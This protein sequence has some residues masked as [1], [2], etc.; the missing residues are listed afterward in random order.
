MRRIP[1]LT[2]LATATMVVLL[3]GVW[4]PPAAAHGD[5]AAISVVSGEPGGDGSVHYRVRVVYENDGD[6]V[7]GVVGTAIASAAGVDQPAVPLTAV[8]GV[9]GD[10]EATVALPGP[11]PWTVRFEATDPEAVLSVEGVVPST[12]MPPTTTS[13][14]PPTTVLPTTVPSTTAAPSS[15]ASAANAAA[16]QRDDDGRG[17][18][19]P[20]LAVVTGL[21]VVAAA[22]G[23]SA[24]R[25][26]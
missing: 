2:A 5:A 8:A 11:G 12:T 26:R 18:T 13:T 6:P 16:E 25:K 24:R 22:V 23:V 1:A 20:V 4:V 10:Y 7:P 21:V 15:G 17:S 14:V 19:G 9:I 3:G